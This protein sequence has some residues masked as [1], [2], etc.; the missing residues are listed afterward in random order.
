MRKKEG[1]AKLVLFGML[2][3]MAGFMSSCVSEY[4]LT[5]VDTYVGPGGGPVPATMATAVPASEPT[6]GPAAEMPAIPP[7]GPLQLNVYQ[8]LV[9]A[10]N[11]NKAL[12]VD[13]YTAPVR[14]TFED[15]DLSQ[16]D[17]VLFGGVVGGRTKVVRGDPPANIAFTDG[18]V[19][20]GL[21]EFLPTGTRLTVSGDAAILHGTSVGEEDAA[22]LE[23]SG[24]QSLLRG[25]GLD[26]NLA[27][28]HQ[29]QI[30]TVSSEYEL[31]GLA[32]SILAQTEE[33][34]WDYLLSIRQEEIVVRSLG[35][36]QQQLTE[37]NT[38]IEVGRLAE[39]ERAAAEA[40]VALRRE[41]L[42]DA[43]SAMARTRLVLLRLLS[44]P[45]ANALDR[46]VLL[47]RQP[48]VKNIPLDPLEEHLSLADRLRPELNQ[49]RL[50]VNRNELDIVKTRN[51]LLPR[52]DLFVTLGKSGYSDSFGQ[53]AGE[54]FTRGS[55]NA[56]VGVVAEYPLGNRGPK[57]QFDRAVLGRDQSI[58]AL[59]NL[60]QLVE[61]DVRNSYIEVARTREQIVATAASRKLQEEKLRAE[62][63]KFR[64]GRSTSLQVAQVQRDL[65]SSQLTEVQALANCLKAYVELYRFDGSLLERRGIAAPGKGPV[66]LT[67]RQ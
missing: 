54:L 15:E 19:G 14:R 47:E 39:T 52:L 29:A 35:L 4:D 13:K 31:R 57:A 40:E 38:R 65:Q 17:P 5:R 45:G 36:A 42:I 1:P 21:T 56:L 30:D 10:L 62:T 37:I 66:K 18:N 64:V 24:T 59:E 16:F 12:I 26:V 60:A 53:A 20:G 25:Y 27:S 58:K 43:R 23:F 8:A 7:A 49:A 28:L 61:V 33:A 22:H 48:M 55:Y 34:Y 6:T 3:V 9:V 63:E 50:Q 44:P 51:G 32:I 11:N 2:S 41:D 67:A 46:E